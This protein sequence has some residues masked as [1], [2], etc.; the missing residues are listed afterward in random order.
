MDY[1]KTF[2]SNSVGGSSNQF[3]FEQNETKI[4]TGRMF[5]KIYSG[6]KFGYSILFS[7]TVDSTF[8]DGSKSQANLKC[9]SWK[10]I[11]AKVG[12]CKKMPYGNG[13]TGATMS[14][15]DCDADI[16]VNDFKPLTFGC[17]L[18]KDVASGEMF[19]SDSIEMEF[20]KNEF[21][22]L[23]ITF[24]GKQIPYHEETLLPAYIKTETGWVYSKFMPC[25][26]MIGCDRKVNKKVCFLGDSI[27]QGC[28]TPLNGYLHWNARLTENLN[29]KNSYWNL[30]IGFGR[31]ND[32][33]TD[34]SWLFKAKQN[35]IVFVCFGVNDIFKIGN[36][37]KT[38]NDLLKI[39]NILKR[40]NK[41]VIIQTVPPFNYDEEKKI[42]WKE[43]NCF[44]KNDLAKICDAVFDCVPILGCSPE[45]SHMAKYGGHPNEF[46]CEL[47]AQALL[48]YINENEKLK[49]L[50]IL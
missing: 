30:G 49:N 13:V 16:Y 48:K 39:V 23:E 26:S 35:D 4:T 3:Y 37:E 21:L 14:D 10:I 34:E 1:F 17:N 22:C 42:I 41:F 12:R 36:T 11:E 6:G 50:L 7:N 19:Y 40:N 27:T 45:N 9:D 24:S 38:K 43:I 8:A 20:E 47:W 25:A 44:I 15:T 28:G 2:S 33:A 5:Y 32:A 29:P 31:A 18:Q 46:G